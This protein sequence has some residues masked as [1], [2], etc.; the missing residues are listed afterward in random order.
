MWAKSGQSPDQLATVTEAIA[1]AIPLGRLGE[2][3]E[4][5]ATVAFLFSDDADCVTGDDIVVGGG[6]GLRA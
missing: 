4:A 2:A 1:A 3:R 5:V 6:A